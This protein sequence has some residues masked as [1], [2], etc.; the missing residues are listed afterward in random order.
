MIWEGEKLGVGCVASC[1][2]GEGAVGY[3]KRRHQGL[4]QVINSG[5]QDLF[6]E[7]FR[8]DPP[9]FTS[10]THQHRVKVQLEATNKQMMLQNVLHLR[11]NLIRTITMYGT[12]M[13]VTCYFCKLLLSH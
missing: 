6:F 3:S 5:G 13:P 9:T 11:A 1:F 2:H 8:F 4:R 10:M 12:L 7:F